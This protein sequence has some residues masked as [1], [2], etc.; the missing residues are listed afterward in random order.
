[1]DSP[2]MRQHLSPSCSVRSHMTELIQCALCTGDDGRAVPRQ[3]Q[4]C[5][6]QM[7]S[8]DLLRR[9]IS[10]GSLFALARF[11]KDLSSDMIPV[12]KLLY[13]KNLARTTRN[14]AFQHFKSIQAFS[15]LFDVLRLPN[16]LPCPLVF[17]RVCIRVA[18]YPRYSCPSCLSGAL[19]LR[20]LQDFHHASSSCT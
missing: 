11:S 18:A 13:C 20:V 2:G 5:E 3:M 8:L 1:M 6:R 12:L 7:R 16:I 19:Q 9:H 4:A 17:R 10:N 15:E 14:S